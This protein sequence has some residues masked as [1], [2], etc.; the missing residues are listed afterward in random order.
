MNRI[1]NQSW[2]SSC[3]IRISILSLSWTCI[4]NPTSKMNWMVYK[5]EYSNGRSAV[6]RLEEEDFVLWYGEVLW[7]SRE[8][9]MIGIVWNLTRSA[10]IANRWNIWIYIRQQGDHGRFQKLGHCLNGGVLY[11]PSCHSCWASILD[12]YPHDPSSSAEDLHCPPSPSPSQHLTCASF[13]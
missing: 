12:Q 11:Q 8:V 9:G 2:H 4:L 3:R 7:P 10:N 6:M 5:V 13:L 1:I